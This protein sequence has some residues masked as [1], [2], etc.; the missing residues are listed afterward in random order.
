MW[1]APPKAHAN[2]YLYPALH[3]YAQQSQVHVEDPDGA[4]R[5]GATDP[6][7][8]IERQVFSRFAKDNNTTYVLNESCADSGRTTDHRGGKRQP[9]DLGLGWRWYTVDLQPGEVL[10]LPPYWYVEEGS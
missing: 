4:M 9:S 5:W 10:F 1:Q 3:P 8:S 6:R 2:L 7:A